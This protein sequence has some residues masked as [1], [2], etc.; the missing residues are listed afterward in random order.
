MLDQKSGRELSKFSV[1]SL[2]K[3]LVE[4]GQ[5]EVEHLEQAVSSIKESHSIQ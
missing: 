1:F 5:L 4:S 3:K 2:M